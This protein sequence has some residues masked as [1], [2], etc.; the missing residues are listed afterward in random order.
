[1]SARIVAVAA[2][3]GLLAMAS[4]ASA[5]GAPQNPASRGYACRTSSSAACR[6]AG[7]EVT[8]AWDDVRVPNVNGRDRQMIPNGKLCSGGLARFQSLDAP[9]SDWPTT[10]LA[11]GARFTFRYRASI[12]H[13]GSF[14]LYVTRDGYRPTARLTWSALESKPFLQVKDPPMRDGSYTFTGKL[15]AS[16]S[17][18]HV[19]YTIWQTT[20]TPDTY[21]SCSDVLFKAPKKPAAAAPARPHR[22]PTPTATPPEQPAGQQPST[23]PAT[24][25]AADPVAAKSKATSKGGPG[26]LMLV[27]AG[28]TVLL[29]LAGGAFT[30]LLIRR[31]RLRRDPF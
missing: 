20:S 24:A 19:I 12:P 31:S 15:P 21:Y 17:G 4:P 16:K 25:P 2:G 9:R 22:S 7:A 6:A 3:L 14:R 30:L 10:T 23:A 28:G 18:H 8:R 5:H 27:A 13:E 11:S 1:M 26:S 29:L